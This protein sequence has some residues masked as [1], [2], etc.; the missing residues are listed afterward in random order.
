MIYLALSILSATLI[1]VAFKF[2]DIFKV[3]TL[4]AIIVNYITA[5]TLG[6]LLYQGKVELQP[7]LDAPWAWGTVAMGI[8][9][10]CIFNLMALTSQRSGVSVASVATKM[11]LVIPVLMGV[12]LY[13]DRLSPWQFLGILFALAAVLLASL[14]DEKIKIR[15]KDLLLPVLVFLGS[16]IIDVGIKY[17]E[18][19][20]LQDREIPLFSAMVFG[21]AA[22]TGLIFVVSKGLGKS[23]KV[24]AKDILGGI[25]LGV[26]NYFSIYFLIRALRW[27]AFNSAAIFTL[28]NVGIVLFSTLLGILMFRERLSPKN[29]SGV[30]L[31]V[32]GIILVALF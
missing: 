31:A 22:L 2:F 11:S 21:S 27:E 18:E 26:P 13:G 20:Y 25:C 29:W 32:V 28:N 23:Q 24:R 30:A 6:L 1:F 4:N 19:L 12:V 10:I 8:L 15:S 14:K 16:G 17:F 5:S 7:L 3:N 9:F